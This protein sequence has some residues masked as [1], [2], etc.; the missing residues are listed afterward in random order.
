M[1]IFQ[2][3]ETCDITHF[4][5][6]PSFDETRCLQRV[7]VLH[8]L[9]SFSE[10]VQHCAIT[11]GY[12][13]VMG[14]LYSIQI[15][16]AAALFRKQ[17]ELRTLY[18]SLA[19]GLPAYCRRSASNVSAPATKARDNL[20]K[21]NLGSPKNDYITWMGLNGAPLPLESRFEYEDNDLV[22]Y[23]SFMSELEQQI[24][25]SSALK[26]LDSMSSSSERK[27]RREWLRAN[28]TKGTSTE[29]DSASL[30]LF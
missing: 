27:K 14:F 29:L 5:R 17:L 6:S 4:A 18:T 19:Y 23:P 12:S 13:S 21:F 24:L 11:F 2:P 26:K 3:I 7:L 28:G 22:V 20:Q 15:S 1:H 16:M 9:S 8:S 10:H 30:N 25:L